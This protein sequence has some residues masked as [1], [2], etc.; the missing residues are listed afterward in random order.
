MKKINLFLLLLLSSLVIITVTMQASFQHWSGEWDLDFWFIYNASL[1]S[2][3]IQQEWYD[4]PATTFLSLYS[5]FYKIYSFFDFSFI[6]KI[7]EIIDSSNPDIVIQK[8]FFVTKI[9]DSVNTILLIFFTF[10]VSKI[11]SSKDI[12]AY[13]SVLILL[14][15]TAFL[16]NISILNSDDWAILFFVVSFYYLLKFFISQNII[17]LFLSGLFFCFSYFSKIHMLFLFFFVILLIPILYEIYSAKSYGSLQKRLENNFSLIFG[18]YLI[19]ILVYFLVNILILDKIGPLS[20]NAG[21]DAIIILFLNFIIVSFFFIF[22]K[23]DFLK[24]KKYFSIFILFLSGFFAGLIIFIAIDILN[25]VDLN[26]KIVVHLVKP[27][28]K[29]LHFAYAPAGMETNMLGTAMQVTSMNIIDKM[30]LVLSKAFSNFYF[31]NFLFT[32]L[33]FI[34]ILSIFKDLKNKNTYLILFKLII[35]FSLVFNTLIFNFRWWAEYNIY[36]YVLYIILLSI[37]LKNISNKIVKSFCTIII[38]YV[39]IFLPITNSSL[40]SA[41]GIIP[42]TQTHTTWKSILSNRPSILEKLCNNFGTNKP[43]SWFI[44]DRYSNEFDAEFFSKICNVPKNRF[45]VSGDKY[46]LE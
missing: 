11:L 37:C 2:S 45:S 1:M 28:Y 35:F 30:L 42:G 44:F 31:D 36:I 15:S 5:I 43:V 34:L 21:L 18:G 20:R 10:K 41:D 6:Y 33:C 14:F 29:M 12:Y 16:M 22:G 17:F 25:I 3:G 4:H 27:F 38:I 46:F 9:F 40:Y 32:G 7:E 8:L 19:S 39:V 23:F 26:P 24:F 13:F